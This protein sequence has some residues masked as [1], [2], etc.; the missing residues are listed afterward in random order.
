M[1]DNVRRVAR[2]DE[3]VVSGVPEQQTTVSQTNATSDAETTRVNAVPV[4]GQS[5]VQSTTTSTAPSD[6]VVQRSVAEQEYDPVAN[7]VAALDWV[8]RLVWFIIG[9]M[10]IL[11][12]IRFVL[13]LAGANDTV[14]FAQLIYGLTGWMVAPFMGIFGQNPT[15]PGTAGVGVF[16]PEALLA[17]VV[18]FLIGWIVTKIAELLLVPSGRRG[19]VYSETQRRTKV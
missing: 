12:A 17:I 16:E 13:L 4:A 19:T 10:A 8:I 11:L 3:T 15:Y 2:D 5:T 9:L 6:Q 14:G 7:R 18:Y 1:D